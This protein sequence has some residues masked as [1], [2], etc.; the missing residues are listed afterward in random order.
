MVLLRIFTRFY[1]ISIT[2]CVEIELHQNYRKK[3]V[4]RKTRRILYR[5]N[6]IWKGLPTALYLNFLSFKTMQEL[7]NL[8]CQN[9]PK[10][11]LLA[12]KQN[13]KKKSNFSFQTA[14]LLTNIPSKSSQIR[15]CFRKPAPWS[16]QRPSRIHKK[17][18]KRSLSTMQVL[19][20]SFFLSSSTR[21]THAL[22]R[23]N[24]RKTP[25]LKQSKS[26]QISSPVFGQARHVNTR[27]TKTLSRANFVHFREL[28]GKL[29]I[30]KWRPNQC[31]ENE[32]GTTN[33]TYYFF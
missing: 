22:I 24:P 13:E 33:R 32:V 1:F 28:N 10:Q 25:R 2:S 8:A 31:L 29:L 15:S 12:R 11:Q 21:V 30:E 16:Q 23:M 4:D 20:F 5:F 18:P 9:S 19:L 14:T 3:T 6:L 17:I 26:E 27:K 7:W